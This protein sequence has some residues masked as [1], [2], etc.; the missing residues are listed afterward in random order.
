MSTS[1]YVCVFVHEDI[2]QTT[3]AKFL[4]IFVH[5]ANGRGTVL[6]RQGDEIPRERGNC[7]KNVPDKPNTPN[8]FKLDWSLQRHKTGANA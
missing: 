4:S 1:V 6:L 8:N 2:S 7:G 5:A 3:H